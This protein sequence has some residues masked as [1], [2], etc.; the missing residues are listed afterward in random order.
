MRSVNCTV[1]TR[2]YFLIMKIL[3]LSNSLE[4]KRGRDLTS[5]QIALRFNVKYHSSYH[6]SDCNHNQLSLDCV[7]RTLARYE[8]VSI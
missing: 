7:I 8:I 4:R 6:Y 3:L 5:F 2:L 1:E